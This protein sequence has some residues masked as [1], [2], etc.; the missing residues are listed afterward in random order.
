VD[1]CRVVVV[2]GT[3]LTSSEEA[4]LVADLDVH[5]KNMNIIN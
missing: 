3:A 4:A 2:E 1:F 5:E